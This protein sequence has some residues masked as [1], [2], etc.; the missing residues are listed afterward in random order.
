[1]PEARSGEDVSTSDSEIEDSFG[2]EV[3]TFADPFG[4]AD[5][6]IEDVA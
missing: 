1:M 3:A 5:E 6:A 4:S 2:R